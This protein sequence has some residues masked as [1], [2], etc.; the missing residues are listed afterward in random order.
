[1]VT[2]PDEHSAEWTYSA[3][4]RVR[5]ATRHLVLALE[6]DRQREPGDTRT[7]DSGHAVAVLA[8]AMQREQSE[9]IASSALDR[10]EGLT[11]VR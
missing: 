9:E 8:E 4:S 1:M 10:R 2:T 11:P 3:A 6:T 5:G 7:L